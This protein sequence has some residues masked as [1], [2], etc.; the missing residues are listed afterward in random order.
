MKLFGQIGSKFLAGFTDEKPISQLV[1]NCSSESGI[2]VHQ[3]TDKS[4]YA[5][6]QF[7]ENAEITC[8]AIDDSGQ[9]SG[10]RTWNLEIPISVTSESDILLNP[11]PIDIDFN[12][13]WPDISLDYVFTQ[14]QN[15]N[16]ANKESVTINSDASIDIYSSEMIPGLVNLWMSID[17]DSV[18][19]TEKIFILGIIKESSPP[20][21]SV[22]EYGWEMDIWQAQGQ[23]S[24]PDGENVDFSLSIDG[25]SAGSISVSGN[26]WS[27]PMIKFLDYGMKECM[28]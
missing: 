7:G 2:N 19:Y 17:G 11:H 12:E 21:I 25:L 4:F 9:S 28:K 26:S 5:T 20:V 22:S 10:I 16:S 8:E 6:I 1:I 24:D 3:S 18:Y 23:F 14:S 15:I 13:G 27:T